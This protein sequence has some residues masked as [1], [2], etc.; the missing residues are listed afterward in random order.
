M[1]KLVSGFEAEKD[2][3]VKE[4]ASTLQK[5]LSAIFETERKL[6]D[7]ENKAKDELLPSR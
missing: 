2:K 7:Q 4:T 1:R 6:R 3:A 5:E